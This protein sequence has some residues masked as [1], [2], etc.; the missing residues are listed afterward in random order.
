VLAARDLR[1]GSGRHSIADLRGAADGCSAGSG[2][3]LGGTCFAAIGQAEVLSVNLSERSVTMTKTSAPR[4]QLS[5]DALFRSI[6][7]SFQGIPDPRT[8]KPTISLPDALMSGLAMFA[9][10]D[11]SMLAFDQR[12]QQDE[13]SL[14]MIFHVENVPCDTRMREVLDPVNPEHLRPAFSNVF[15]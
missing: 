9:L 8:G 12:R 13:K 10:K 15:T 7:Q 1:T 3:T 4:K 11:P 14:Q 5:A 2:G 6:H